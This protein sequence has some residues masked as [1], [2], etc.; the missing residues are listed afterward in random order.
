MFIDAVGWLGSV[1]VVL[2]YALN[3]AGRLQARSLWYTGCNL[4]GSVCLIANTYHY[5]AYPSMAVN[6]VWVAIAV[7]GLLRR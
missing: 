2:A 1:L 5:R 7:Y 3:V 6:L 4:V